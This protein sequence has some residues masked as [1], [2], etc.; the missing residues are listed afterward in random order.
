M[1][2]PS[3]MSLLDAA[4][5]VLARIGQ[6]DDGVANP[7]LL[8]EAKAHIN[9]VQRKL[10]VEHGLLTQR[11]RALLTIAAG[12]RFADLPA[13][14]RHGQIR[15]A[16]WIDASGDEHQLTCGI[17]P[18]YRNIGALAPAWYDIRPSTGVVSVTAAGGTGYTSGVGTVTGG[19]RLTGGHDPIVTCTSTGGILQSAT[20]IDSG[21]EWSSAPTITAQDGSGG[22]VT[23]TLGAVQ[24]LELCPA[25]TAS[26]TLDIEYQAAVVKLV[27]DA[28][29]L[30]ID[31]EAV[32]CRAAMLLA[33]TKGLPSIDGLRQ[34]FV[35]Y[36]ASFRAQQS[37]G[38]IISL[39]AHR[40]EANEATWG[41]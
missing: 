12:R 4:T 21:S 15:S 3:S 33:I 7:L 19:T 29:Q 11:R 16:T 6:L 30:A 40:R 24:L 22:T 10:V 23:V 14:A 26:G 36:M 2:S 34:D 5:E 1:P 37:P 8:V 38:R 28:D 41:R 9:S 32:I 31:P 18:D 13:D 17:V 35:S 39:S 20:V 25:P 27:D